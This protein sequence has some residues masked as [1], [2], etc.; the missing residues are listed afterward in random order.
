MSYVC[1]YSFVQLDKSRVEKK[2]IARLF[3]KLHDGVY[4][5][6]HL[7]ALCTASEKC[8]VLCCFLSRSRRM[9]VPCSATVGSSLPVGALFFN[10]EI[11][12]TVY[13]DK[14]TVILSII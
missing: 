10:S 5:V 1:A 7:L 8:N 13:I 9:D 6:E 14:S 2:F 11:I 4:G 3:T 12:V